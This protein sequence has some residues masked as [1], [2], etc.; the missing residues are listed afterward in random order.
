VT[1]WRDALAPTPECLA[2]ER[3]AEE[4]TAAEREHVEGCVRC[5]TELALFRDVTS[6]PISPASQWIAAGLQRRSGRAAGRPALRVLYAIAAMVVIAIGLGTWLREPSIDIPRNDQPY[7]SARLELVSPAGDLAQAPNELRWN[8]VPHA[9]RY[10]I[11]ILEVDST[12][13]WSGTTTQPRAALPPAVIA[14][15]RPGKSLQWDVR[16]FRG[17]ELLAASETQTIRVTP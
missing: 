12:V 8:P 1:D 17:N 13:V 10:Q 5:Q 3:L 15:F 9:T 2:I 7:R 14:Q 6:E 4:L 11:R 16:A